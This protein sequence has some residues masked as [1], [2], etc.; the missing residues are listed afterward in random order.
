[1]KSQRPKKRR[2]KSEAMLYTL[3]LGLLSLAQKGGREG[4]AGKDEPA[5]W[6]VPAGVWESLSH[7]WLSVHPVSGRTC[8]QNLTLM[9]SQ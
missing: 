5:V 8:L 3:F 9:M 7:P 2:R 6:G 4:R 1:M